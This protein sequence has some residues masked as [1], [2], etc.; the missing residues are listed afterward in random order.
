MNNVVTWEAQALFLALALPALA[1]GDPA[2]T[3]E[4]RGN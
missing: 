1:Y 3:P 2:E 4:S